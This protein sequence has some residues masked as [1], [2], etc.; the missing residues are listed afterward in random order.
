[1]DKIKKILLNEKIILIFIII[2]SFTI[3]LEGFD[4]FGHD[5]HYFIV[6]VDSLITIIFIVEAIFKIKDEGW[7]KYITQNWNKMDFVLVLLSLPSLFLVLFKNIH[8]ADLSFLLILRISRVFRFFRFF[9]FIPGI[10]HLLKGIQRSL[11]ASLFVLLAFFIYNFTTSI[12]SCYLFKHTSPELFG[13]PL[14]AFYSTFKIFTVEGWYEIPETLTQ[15]MS[16]S[17]DIFVKAYFIIILITGGIFGLSLVNSVF[18]DSMVSDNNDELEEK[19]DEL[20]KKVD[21]LLKK[22]E[23]K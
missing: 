6:W 12:L 15:N 19:V 21:L 20:N 13:N 4:E 14:K 3:F 9:R 1:M 17:S 22:L 10:E 7:R 11:K 2:N 23:E 18:V 8:A 5:F 16:T